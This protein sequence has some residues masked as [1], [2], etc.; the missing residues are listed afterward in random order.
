MADEKKFPNGTPMPNGQ[1]PKGAPGGKPGA[2]GQR[3]LT[4]DELRALQKKNGAGGNHRGPGGPMIREK[5]KDVKGTVVK[6]MKYIGKSKYLVVAIM[7]TTLVTTFLSLLGPKLQGKAI[8]AITL[9]DGQLHVDFDSL[10]KYLVLMLV[11]YVGS[12]L[13]TMLQGFASHRSRRQRYSPSVR[14][15]S[16][17]SPTSRSGIRTTT[18]AATS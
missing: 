4:A 15:C 2:P 14:I 3:E 12:S 9:T 7:I 10:V 8:D 1:P 18:R 17:R 13:V 6:L 16:A 11:V 5:P